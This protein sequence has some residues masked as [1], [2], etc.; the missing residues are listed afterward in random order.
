MTLETIERQVPNER[1][2]GIDL[3]TRKSIYQ[4]VQQGVKFPEEPVFSSPPMSVSI[5]S[6]AWSRPAELSLFTDLITDLPAT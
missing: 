3:K 5:V 6:S 1:F 2:D 4:P